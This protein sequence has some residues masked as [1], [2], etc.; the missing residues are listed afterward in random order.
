MSVKIIS[1]VLLIVVAGAFLVNGLTSDL[2]KP[3]LNNTQNNMSVSEEADALKKFD[4]PE[5]IEEFLKKHME[6]QEY[7]FRG[8]FDIVGAPMIQFK[9]S[10]LGVAEL[11][12]L[13][14][15]ASTGTDDYSTT[16]IQVRG[17]DEADIVK[18]DGKYIYV[19]SNGRVS[20]L[21]AYPPE[22]A[23]IISTIK[24]GGNPQELFVSKDR[25]VILG[26]DYTLVEP[27]EFR[28]KSKPST[29]A[30]EEMDIYPG[31]ISSPFAVLS[32]YNVR[33]RSH[34]KLIDEIRVDGNY[35]DSRMIG[36]Y[37]YLIATQPT[38]YYG[39]GI[40][41]PEIST[42]TSKISSLTPPD[43]YYFDVP[44]YSYAFTSIVSVNVEKGK[45]AE[46]K[47][48]LL[49]STQNMFVS[50]ENIFVTYQ[51]WTQRPVL[52][53][54]LIDS[55]IKPLMPSSVNERLE[56]I[57]DSNKTSWEKEQMKSIEREIIKE[58]EKTVVHRIEINEG[59]VVYRASG[60][61]PGRVLNQFSM[62]E[63]K[64]HF[65]IATT[66]GHLSGRDIQTTANHIYIL[67]NDL[68][69]VGSVEDLAPGEQ[70]YSARF[71]GN[72]A[73]LVTFQKV[74]PL[75]VIDLSNP[76]NPKVL[77]KLKIP[78]Y[79]DYL[80]PYD[81][82]HIIGIGKDA[83]EAERGNFAWYQGV[84]VALFDVSNVRRPKEISNYI[85]GDRGTDSP[86][87]HD[88]KAFLFSKEKNL[89]V[90][91]VL[92]AEIDYEKYPGELPDNAYGD[93]VWQG[94]YVFD[95]DT[96]SGIG[97]RGRISHGNN[98]ASLLKSG[99]FYYGSMNSIK[100]S[101]YMDDALYTISEVMVQMNNLESLKRIN[102]VHLSR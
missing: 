70:I 61:V 15:L 93:Y 42:T 91:P 83:V 44:D 13:A 6:N 21:D 56:S 35:F 65:R 69:I 20:I 77:G 57:R 27:T 38:Y 52:Y 32:I 82:N 30:T 84:K 59:E 29:M 53:E 100:R 99:R 26:N 9:S 12:S 51:K 79:S 80:H 102:R 48:Y 24:L 46:D 97:L 36:D 47:I 43:I 71:M 25:L 19:L 73:Y 90:I 23:Q 85:I 88:H 45:I 66:T 16:N 1:V 68:E 7:R 75:F 81:E 40:Q 55:A 96:K 74:D 64:E 10:G 94:A 31:E 8:G 50:L 3:T 5:E 41:I 33:D 4:S 63:F 60:E 14:T 78:G 86:A 76:R 54:K 49:G 18:N 62:D 37:V 17:V 101:L 28:G 89:L 11:E 95:V 72:R 92:L 2:P 39:D 98:D 22:D 67:D 58:T 87:L 34:P